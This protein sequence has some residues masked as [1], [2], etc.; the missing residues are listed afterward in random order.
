LLAGYPELIHGFN[1]FLPPGYKIESGTEGYPTAQRIM[2]PSGSTPFF[3]HRDVPPSEVSVNATATDE[4]GSPSSPPVQYFQLAEELHKAS[5]AF[6]QGDAAI[7]PAI[8]ARPLDE[9]LEESGY[10]VATP[11]FDNGSP[12]LTSSSSEA[13]PQPPSLLIS[14]TSD[15]T[16]PENHLIENG[17]VELPASEPP[18]PAIDHH[19]T[20]STQLHDTSNTQFP[21]LG[22]TILYSA[23]HTAGLG[24]QQREALNVQLN[25]RYRDLHPMVASYTSSQKEAIRNESSDHTTD[26]QSPAA[27]APQTSTRPSEEMKATS[28]ELKEVRRQI[29]LL[30]DL[31][32]AADRAEMGR[33]KPES[34]KSSSNPSLPQMANDGQQQNNTDKDPQDQGPASHSPSSQSNPSTPKSPPPDPTLPQNRPSSTLSPPS[35]S[36]S[37][38]TSTPPSFPPHP[39]PSLTTPTPI[40]TLPSLTHLQHLATLDSVE[41]ENDARGGP[42]RLSFDEFEE[43]MKGEKGRKLGFVGAWIEMASF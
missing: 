31:G 22:Q 35:P 11:S 21:V 30:L 29:V 10:S 34:D 13:Q 28:K 7:E 25:A 2:T 23:K 14:P 43:I 20:Q 24:P 40:P 41:L 19:Q 38:Q 42:G 1:V 33:R 39:P 32:I 6:D 12:L 8:L 3:V 18:K 37:L 16:S 17:V 4:T 5:I 9:L 36:P 27:E 15:E 26:P